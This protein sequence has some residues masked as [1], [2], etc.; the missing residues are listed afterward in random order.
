[1]QTAAVLG[2]EFDMRLLARMLH[3][4]ET[5]PQKVSWAEQ[6]AIWT[7]LNELRYIFKHALL[8]DAAYSMQLRARRQHL[9]RLAAEA[10]EK[11]YA[12]DLRYRYGELAYHS[13]KAGLVEQA[14]YYLPLAG[15]TARDAYQNSLAIE[16]YSRALKLTPAS[17]LEAR[18]SLH[19][20]REA[21]YD[22]QGERGEQ[23]HELNALHSLAL[24]LE[25]TEKQA[26]AKIRHATYLTNLG[27]YREGSLM[28]EEAISLA[29]K[30]GLKKMAIG[31]H[32]AACDALYKQ[33]DYE[34]A[35]QHGE[36]G[37]A[38]AREISA[39]S[40]EGRILNMLGLVVLD[41]QN[42]TAAETFFEQSLTIHREIGELRNQAMPLN[43]LGMLSGFQGDYAAAQNYYKQSLAI[44]QEIGHRTGEGLVLG[45]LGWVTGV[46][47]DFASARTYAEQMIR[48][49]REVGSRLVEMYGLLQLSMYTGG[50]GEFTI[51]LKYAEQGLELARE[52][53]DRSGEAW[54]L[55]YQGHA[56]LALKRVP[57]A[58]AAYQGALDIRYELDQPVLATEPS[59]GLAR[60][61]L[62]QNNLH[63]AQS[64]IASILTHLDSGGS[65]DG[66]D[67]PLRVYLTCYLVLQAAKDKRANPILELA[68]NLLLVRADNIKDEATR[69][70][71]LE[72]IPY[73]REILEAWG[74]HQG[75]EEFT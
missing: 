20:A 68:R 41:Q 45:N 43:N 48:I 38:L 11:V 23:Q 58:R 27:D 60:V 75:K 50:V 31:A 56:L 55:T 33:G 19:Y 22:L 69:I 65:L 59:A 37:I 67:E 42:L 51:S 5:L 28:A 17:E 47:G 14:R 32:S 52:T 10:L 36:T 62:E 74:R 12:D 21:I 25:D 71:F 46:L 9:H 72:N 64:Q 26:E 13:E 73:H 8:R 34:V 53:H 40:V 44:A 61:A 24:E 66:T 39:R 18:Y 29:Q 49:G 57:E 4:D 54:A 3:G 16:Y 63:A 2:R 70:T 1:M 7:A 6:A 15:D 35:I 30:A